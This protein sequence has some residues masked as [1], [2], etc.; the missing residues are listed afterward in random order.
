MDGPKP[1]RK[2][3]ILGLPSVGKTTF[4]SMLQGKPLDI[5]EPTSGCNK[6]MLSREKVNLDLLDVG[7]APQV[8]RF[9]PQIA[10]EAQGLIMLVN[11]SEADDLSWAQLAREVRIVRKSRPLLVL[12]SQY[13]LS[14]R[15]C[16]P[17]HDAMNRLGLHLAGGV[18]N[19]FTIA[20]STDVK[21]A[22]A[23]IAW[24]CQRMLATDEG[25]GGG[26]DDDGIYEPAEPAEMYA[27]SLRPPQPPTPPAESTP[28]GSRLRIMSEIQRARQE[29]GNEETEINELQQRLMDGHILSETDL[30]RIRSAHRSK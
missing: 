26:D 30:E 11:A 9:W 5:V 27:P 12:L 21:G 17:P 1:R 22:E 25:E 18:T 29:N 7:G 2:V 19:S 23:G 14:P 28:R 10:Q 6:S 13:G 15:I 16:V 20:S 3:A 24:L 8:R 4:I